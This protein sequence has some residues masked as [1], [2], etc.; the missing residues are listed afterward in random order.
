[1]AE[2]GELVKLEIK[3]FEDVKFST[4][5]GSFK[6]QM[7]PES[8]SL[9]TSVINQTEVLQ[10]N[11]EPVETSKQPNRRK[12]NL[13]FYLDSTGVVPG[14]TSVPSS[15]ESFHKVCADINGNIHTSNYLKIYWGEGL[16]F[17]CRLECATVDYLMFKPSG[18]PVRVMVKADFKE[19]I[20]ADTAAKE[21]GKSSPDM[22][23][24]KT[25]RAG[26]NLPALCQ[27]IYGDS[28]LYIQIAQ[29]NNILNFKQ[30]EPGM[31]VHFPRMQK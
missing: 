31:E 4:D 17:P 5:A 16:A 24:I 1:M 7:N 11:N 8:Y 2:E 18:E 22:T 25:I 27:E 14:C 23:H 21:S 30:L 15:L 20:D 29:Y 19:F 9:T 13:T 26:D 12:L 6:M 10:A 28:S 3:A